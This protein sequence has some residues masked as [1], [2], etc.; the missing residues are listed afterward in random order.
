MAINRIHAPIWKLSPA[1]REAAVRR[2][3]K[4]IFDQY[5]T[6]RLGNPRNS[7]DDLV[8]IILSNKTSPAQAT[9]VFRLLRNHFVTWNRVLR[10]KRSTIQQILRPAGLAKIKSYYLRNLLA[11][12]SSDFG[13]CTLA[14]LKRLGD[15]DVSAYLESLPGVSTKVS[16][17]V[18]MYTMERKV[19]PVDAHVHRVALPPP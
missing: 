19:L 15:D 4:R 1:K 14:P 11:R 7:L 6:G 2:V 13:G 5:G 8:Y 18:M 10:A 9:K 3:C 16:K 12:V 17:C